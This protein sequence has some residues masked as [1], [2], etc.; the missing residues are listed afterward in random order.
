VLAPTWRQRRS[1]AGRGVRVSKKVC[2]ADDL[3]VHAGR[4]G[5]HSIIAHELVP[6]SIVQRLR[7]RAVIEPEIVAEELL[8]LCAI[9]MLERT[10]FDHERA[11]TAA[12]ASAIGGDAKP[13]HGLSAAGHWDAANCPRSIPDY[14]P[15]ARRNVGGRTLGDSLLPVR[16]LHV[17]ATRR[18]CA[19]AEEILDDF[20]APGTS[21]CRAF[22]RVLYVSGNSHNG[23]LIPNVSSAIR[24]CRHAQRL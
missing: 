2:D 21:V 6:G 16:R 12:N 7:R 3:A 23:R 24:D 9:A 10:H 13:T 11:P 22:V 18:D 8:P 20:G 14:P 19:R 17:V 1:V 5:V 4:E 15:T